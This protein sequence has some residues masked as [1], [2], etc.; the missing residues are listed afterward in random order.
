MGLFLSQKHPARFTNSSFIDTISSGIFHGICRCEA[1]SGMIFL[2][3]ECGFMLKRLVFSFLLFLMILCPLGGFPHFFQ[4]KPEDA[5]IDE[6][7]AH[8]NNRELLGQIYFLGFVGETGDAY[9]ENWIKRRNLGGVKIFSRNVKDIP[10]ITKE[11]HR[12]QTIAAG[13][14]FKIPLFV[15]TDQ[16]GGWVRH[17][18]NETIR[19]PGNLAVGATGLPYDAYWTG[20]YIGREL[21]LMGINMNYAPTVDIYSTPLNTAIGPRSFSSDPVETGLFALAFYHGME[22]AGVIC[23]AKHFP[24]H[25]GTELDSHGY[26]PEVMID[27]EGMFHRELVPYKFLIKEGL[28]AIMTG[29][30]AYPLVLDDKTPA[31]LSSFFLTKVLR[32]DLGFRGVLMT[33]DLEMYGARNAS[34][35]F[36]EVTYRAVMAGNDMLL[37]SHRP[38]R[39]EVSWNHLIRLM[40]R[41]GAFKSRVKESVRRILKQKMRFFK[42]PNAFVIYPDYKN[43]EKHIQL[44][45]LHY[46][47]DFLFQTA[48]RSTTL[49][50]DKKIPY[51]KEE[52][53]KLLITGQ[54]SEFIRQ[55]LLRYPGADFFDFSYSP[56]HRAVPEEAAALEKLVRSYDRVIFCLANKNSLG[57]LKRLRPYGDKIIVLSTLTPVYLDSVPW[58]DTAVAVYGTS[59]ESFQAGFAA[60]TGDFKPEGK[61]PLYF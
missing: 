25:G 3:K 22:K 1:P 49:L 17:I 57:V 35:R 50:K 36:E 26:L 38:G 61:L 55:G 33:D 53:E 58:V 41:D 5:L 24:G 31:T 29:H 7:I 43:I 19:T 18:K 30:L 10:S 44:L 2:S 34:D 8:M 12:F 56:I 11:I 60:I 54:Y 48:C 13:G 32:E 40:E 14:R 16:E 23:T 47:G 46:S 6:I 9:Y 42:G 20:Y 27:L 15:A 37:I 21:S 59:P 52:K 28:P 51:I 4:D 45:Q 39:Q